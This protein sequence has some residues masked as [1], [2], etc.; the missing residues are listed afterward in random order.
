MKLARRLCVT[1]GGLKRWIDQQAT[2]SAEDQQVFGVRGAA[3]QKEEVAGASVPLAE[4][5]PL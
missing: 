1:E 2:Q 3:D 5:D 4:K